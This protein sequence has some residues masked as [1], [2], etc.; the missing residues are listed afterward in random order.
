MKECPSPQPPGSLRR[1][2]AGVFLV[3]AAMVGIAAS[4]NPGPGAD[5]TVYGR[6]MLVVSSASVTPRPGMEASFPRVFDLKLTVS[7]IGSI[8]ANH[9]LATLPENPYVSAENGSAFFGFNF[10]YAGKTADVVL[11]MTLDSA[12]SSGR[13]QP[14]F[15]FEYYEY[16]EDDDTIV[17]YTGDEPVP[18]SFGDQGWNRPVLL[19]S[20]VTAVPN[21]PAPGESCLVT[22]RFSNISAGDARQ[23]L[24]RLGGADG[25]KPFALTSSG[26][27]GFV[28]MVR[29]HQT[30]D[31]NFPLIVDGNAA[32]GTYPIQVSLAYQNVLG[33]DSTDTQVV[34]LNVRTQPNLEADIIGELP[35][36]LL[37]GESFELPV[38]VINIGRQS[39]NVSTIE[40]V[41]DDLTLTNASLYSGPLDGSTSASLSATATAAK[42]G[43]AR[44]TLV[45]HYL[46]EFNQPQTWS[47]TFDL[48]IREQS[49][50]VQTAADGEEKPSLLES[51]WKAILA[52]LGFG[53]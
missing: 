3:L 27:V 51:I 43:P 26:N 13:V 47:R 19:I 33:E 48:Q 32:A 49:S 11:H 37:V 6:P 23:L 7:N 12:D 36:P 44:A 53:G 35:S 40:L 28:G 45:V 29:A 9:V 1:T 24:L 21:A 25:P 50:P 42:A 18:L 14:V 20:S 5:I 41:S 4:G 46:D 22:M 30:A 16:N 15:H 8:V 2:A 52:F 38:E 34:Y 31:I 10:I 17:K 39:L